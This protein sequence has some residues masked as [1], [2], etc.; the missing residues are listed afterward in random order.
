MKILILQLARLGDIFQTA[1]VVNALKRIHP[2]CEIHML[3][4]KT[5]SVAAEMINGL[6]HIWTL[7]TRKIL[8][9]LIDERPQIQSSVTELLANLDEIKAVDYDQIINLSFSPFSS[10]LVY[11]LTNATGVD[12]KQGAP[13]IKGYSR[14]SDG[15]FDI[16]DDAS[17][18]FYAQVGPGRSNRLHLTSLF[19]HVAGVE[20]IESDWRMDHPS[21]ESLEFLDY[22]NYKQKMYIAVH[23]GASQLDKTLS[24]SKWLQ[25]VRKLYDQFQG[26]IVFIGTTS[27]QE[28]AD[29]VLLSLSGDRRPVNLIGKT[30]MSQ[31]ADLIRHARLLIGG[32]S[33]PVQIASLVET[34]VLNIS[35]ATV[36]CWETG[37]LSK[38]SRIIP[39][40]DEKDI[41]AEELAKEAFY[42]LQDSDQGMAKLRVESPLLAPKEYGEMPREFEWKLL[43]GIYMEGEFPRPIHDH[44]IDAVIRLAETNRLAMEQIEV[45]KINQGNATIGLILDQADEIIREIGRLVPEVE[46]LVSWY[47]TEKIRIGPMDFDRLVEA[48]MNVHSGFAGLLE[49][50]CLE[51]NDGNEMGGDSRDEISLE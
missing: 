39:I 51:I 27:E 3:V 11:E 31:A 8:E 48:T 20:L 6:D 21:S 26:D 4:R 15:Y 43:Q 47:F 17:A 30:T 36:S 10:Y 40:Q 46:P 45:L 9:P 24:W 18:Y 1:P 41:S 2:N 29:K 32:D 28:I 13:T 25:V 19:G 50:R 7:D 44:Y 38:G 5:F 37:P 16:K 34:P 33:G 22:E 14:L 12:T 35:F 49:V 42:M 23:L